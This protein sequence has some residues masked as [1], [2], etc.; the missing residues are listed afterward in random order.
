MAHREDDDKE[1]EG[2]DQSE[3]LVDQA[4]DETKDEDEEDSTS[5]IGVDEDEKA[6]E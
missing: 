5:G 2:G 3:G 1:K 6:W 4:L